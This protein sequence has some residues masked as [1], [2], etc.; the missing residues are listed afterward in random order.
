MSG[1]EDKAGNYLFADAAPPYLEVCPD[2]V[3]IVDPAGRIRRVNPTLLSF[4]GYEEPHLLGR[5]CRELIHPDDH[6]TV[7]ADLDRLSRGEQIRGSELLVRTVTG[8]YRWVEWNATPLPDQSTVLAVGRDI[9]PRRRR[10]QGDTLLEYAP[11]ALLTL[12]AQERIAWMNG[13]CERLIGHRRAHLKGHP[14]AELLSG[15]GGLLHDASAVGD[16]HSLAECVLTRADGTKLAVDARA[17]RLPHGDAFYHMISL[18][19]VSRRERVEEQLC[20]VESTLDEIRIGYWIWE[21]EQD[22]IEASDELFRC[23]GEAPQSTRLDRRRLLSLVRAGDRQRLVSV[24]EAALEDGRKGFEVGCRSMNGRAVHISGRIYR[25]E[26]GAATRVIGTVQATS[27]R[28]PGKALLEQSEVLSRAVFETTG[29]L[30][31]V[32]DPQGG[33]LRFNRAAERISGYSEEAMRGQKVWDVL[34]PHDEA[35]AIRETFRRLVRGEPRNE[36]RGH[37]LTPEGEQHL[38]AWSDT[39]IRGLAGEVAYVVC[40]GV[41]L[42]G[43]EEAETQLAEVEASYRRLVGLTFDM[44]LVHCND[45]IVSVNPA[46]AAMLGVQHPNE[47]LGRRFSEIF[48]PDYRELIRQHAWRVLEQQTGLPLTEQRL[49]RRDGTAID[50]EVASTPINHR[51]RPAVQSVFRNITGRKRAEAALRV[52]EHYF[53]TLAKVAPVGIFQTDSSGYYLYVNERWVEI[54]GIELTDAMVEGWTG[55]LHPEDRERVVGEWYRSVAQGGALHLE[56][57]FLRPD[58]TVTWVLAR[59]TPERDVAGEVLGYVGTI[60][61]ITHSKRDA[62][63]VQQYRVRLEELVAERTRELSAV[64]QELESFSYSVSHDLRAPLRAINGFAAAFADDCGEELGEEGRY[65]LERIQ[66]NSRHMAELIDQLLEISRVSRLEMRREPVDLAE[67]AQEVTDELRADQPGRTVHVQ[68]ARE[69]QA[70]GDPKML[71][72]VVQ[73]LLCNAWKYTGQRPVARIEFGARESEEGRVFF[74]RDNGAGFDNAHVDK[75]FAAFQRLHSSDDFDGSGIGLA[76]VQRIIHR[77]GGKVWAEGETGNGATFY[78][79]LSGEEGTA[80]QEQLSLLGER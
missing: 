58:G 56:C 39:V 78:F 28:E 62:E 6:P 51:G 9:G 35:G 29:A 75:L 17:R 8:V 20:L 25:D 26:S 12:D 5:D 31:V 61:D 79:T 48:H 59:A 18:R 15:S 72:L 65:Y 30:V 38:I 33:V 53:Q 43:V 50:V 21:V 16:G 66:A 64:N 46:G 32:L 22:L 2:L 74:V 19:E 23:F 60:T 41:D 44:V 13:E 10:S 63:E 34:V 3:A 69:L 4:S 70:L 7:K 54:T 76:T 67:I 14:L 77:H 55:G 80:P 68:I 71:R 37:W 24:L 42:T 11:D 1:I 40:T 49:M 27:G 47:L 36:C 52:R 57:R 45:E 73:N